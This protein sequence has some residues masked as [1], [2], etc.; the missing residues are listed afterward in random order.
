MST[1][2][3]I[4]YNLSLGQGLKVI[5]NSYSEISTNKVRQIRNRIQSNAYFVYELASVYHLVKLEAVKRRIPILA[6]SQAVVNIVNTS[7]HRFFGQLETPLM[8]YYL[9][10]IQRL[11]SQNP[12]LKLLNII[13][14]KGGAKFFKDIELSSS[15]AYKKMPYE[16]IVFKDDLPNKPELGLLANTIGKYETVFVYYSH[17]KNLLTQVPQ[18]AD[19]KQTVLNI[20]PGAQT[21]DHIYEPEI[22]KMVEFF[23]SQIMRS[24]LENTFLESELSRAASRMLSM[25]QAQ[26]R[27]QEYIKK[28]SKLLYSAKKYLLNLRM[29]QTVNS[30]ISWQKGKSDG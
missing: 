18:M 7:N 25:N 11:A 16:P 26:E 29:L 30:F 2:T 22:G 3:K 10:S 13:I 20:K 6:K 19:L 9:T 4:K 24:L 1:L 28:Q 27:A 17:F 8:Y 5:S 21:I 14:G 23:D 12:N 15:F